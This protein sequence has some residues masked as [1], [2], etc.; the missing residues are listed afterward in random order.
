MFEE[1]E[2]NKNIL[3]SKPV[4]DEVIQRYAD[5]LGVSFGQEFKEYIK[6][7]GCISIGSLEFYGICGD[8][9]KI[10]SAIHATKMMRKHIP[11]LSKDLIVF[12]EV[13]DGSFYCID[14]QDEVYL[15]EF[16]KCSKY[17]MKFEQFIL[18]QLSALQ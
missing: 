6:R 4:K 16:D 15:C 18:K 3:K 2:K 13:G 7:F 17:N 14:S 5:E 11:T 8:N 10:P 9:D 1:I 12:Y